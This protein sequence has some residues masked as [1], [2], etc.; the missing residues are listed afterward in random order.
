MTGHGPST[1]E[2]GS[3]KKTLPC[4]QL[5]SAGL[6]SILRALVPFP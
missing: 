2:E 3:R 4:P 5:I 6:K 1:L